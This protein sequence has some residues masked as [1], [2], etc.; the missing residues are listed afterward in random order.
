MEAYW[1][2]RFADKRLKNEWFAL[3]VDD[4]RAFKRWQRICL[5]STCR[6]D[7]N[8]AI[9]SDN[10]GKCDIDQFFANLRLRNEYDLVFPFGR[11]TRISCTDEEFDD[12]GNWNVPCQEY[13]RRLMAAG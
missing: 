3:N 13:A 6:N 5:A 9:A 10:H 2:R 8:D 12:F 4:V 1:R 11:F 7:A